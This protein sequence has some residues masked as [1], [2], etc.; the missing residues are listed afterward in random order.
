MVFMTLF[1]LSLT[2]LQYFLVTVQYVPIFGAHLTYLYFHFHIFLLF[3]FLWEGQLFSAFLQQQPQKHK[4]TTIE[5]TIAA[6]RNQKIPLP[7]A[8]QSLALMPPWQD[9]KFGSLTSLVLSSW[10]PKRKR[11]SI[12]IKPLARFQ[13]KSGQ[14]HPCLPTC[15]LL[16]QMS[17][18]EICPW[19]HQ[20]TAHPG[21]NS[22]MHNF[23]TPPQGSS[24]WLATSSSNTNRTV[25]TAWG[26]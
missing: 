4:Q 5:Q 12:S 8:L 24:T 1:I 11:K 19:N 3:T 23:F 10:S 6:S 26:C 15:C 21:H 16:Q 2:F 18:S 9:D 22:S 7:K 20:S 17:V 13:R 25:C 14:L